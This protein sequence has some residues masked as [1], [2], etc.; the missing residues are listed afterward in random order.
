M[1]EIIGEAAYMITPEFKETHH[2]LNWRK[3]QGMRHHLVHGYYQISPEVLW[4]TIENDI[5]TIIPILKQY[6]EEL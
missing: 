2:E 6:L 1:L 3:I 4:G 5:P